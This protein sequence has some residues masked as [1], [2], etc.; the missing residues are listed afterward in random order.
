ME[1]YQLNFKNDCLGKIICRLLEEKSGKPVFDGKT[2]QEI[3][4]D[5]IGTYALDMIYS[6][7][8]IGKKLDFTYDT[9]TELPVVLASCYRRN[10]S[11]PPPAAINGTVKALAAYFFALAMNEHDFSW[12]VRQMP[13]LL[14]AKNPPKDPLW[15]VFRVQIGEKK[16]ICCFP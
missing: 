14:N 4:E 16:P 13:V 7:L 3:G 10:K 15:G 5:L 2:P 12:D 8:E 9:L 1:T 11:D 6:G